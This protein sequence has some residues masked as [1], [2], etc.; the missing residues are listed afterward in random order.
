MVPFLV[1]KFEQKDEKIRISSLIVVKHLIN[2]CEEEMTNKKQLLISGLRLLLN[3]TS[4]RVKK[5]L[6]Q[7]I[8]AMAY[9]GYLSLEGGHSMIE[10]I[11]KQSNL[12]EIELDVK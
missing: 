9:H 3:E 7:V 1:Q 4:N 10:F 12:Q 11:L 8:I 6:L 5:N 2:S